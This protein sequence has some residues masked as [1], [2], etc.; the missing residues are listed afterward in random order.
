MECRNAP[1]VPTFD[2]DEVDA[3]KAA[4]KEWERKYL[5]REEAYDKQ[6]SV[7]SELEEKLPKELVNTVKALDKTTDESKISKLK[8]QLANLEDHLSH[9]L[10]SLY[11]EWNAARTE[12]AKLD[13]RLE[14]AS[15]HKEAADEV[16]KALLRSLEQLRDQQALKQEKSAWEWLKRPEPIMKWEPGAASSGKRSKATT[17]VPTFYQ[18]DFVKYWDIFDNFELV[19]DQLV[20][21]AT[22]MDNVYNDPL[23]KT[24]AEKTMTS[25]QGNPHYEELRFSAAHEDQVV[26]Q[27]EKIKDRVERVAQRCLKVEFLSA[28]QAQVFDPVGGRPED[29]VLRVVDPVR[30]GSYRFVDHMFSTTDRPSFLLGECKTD[31]SFQSVDLVQYWKNRQLDTSDGLVACALTQLCM[32]MLLFQCKYGMLTN[33]DKTWFI[34]LVTEG[35]KCGIK[36]SKAF[37]TASK[38]GGNNPRP[39]ENPAKMSLSQTMLFMICLALIDGKLK[40]NEWKKFT[41]EQ[42]RIRVDQQNKTIESISKAQTAATAS[43]TRSRTSPRL[44]GAGQH[45]SLPLETID[46]NLDMSRAKVVPIL[47]GSGVGFRKQNIHGYESFVKT[48]SFTTDPDDTEELFNEAKMYMLLQPLWGIVTPT[49]VF[50]GKVSKN[51]FAVIATDEGESLQTKEGHA[52]CIGNEASIYEHAHNALNQIHSLGI[53]HGDVALRNIVIGPDNSIK[54]IDFGRSH[55]SNSQTDF[56]IE[57]DL[58]DKEFMANDWNI[59]LPIATLKPL[60]YDTT[61]KRTRFISKDVMEVSDS[62]DSEATIEVD[63]TIIPQH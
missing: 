32:Y 3:A 54:L 44:G 63:S 42:T 43:T 22:Y 14:E 19:K 47:G 9:E 56:Q 24:L 60:N 23:W 41:P 31:R 7:V 20:K 11:L 49:L 1:A 58:L 15:K 45:N 27:F 59:D 57:H 62:F 48:V 17:R 26:K 6:A 25:D 37:W 46:A 52:R 55:E 38:N 2:T 13:K 18:P 33:Y 10:Q 61:N 29:R 50:Q 12:L 35:D 51:R 4:A 28:P 16:Y 21:R 5:V 8:P 34:C 30:S 40:E 36:V 39:D 53:L